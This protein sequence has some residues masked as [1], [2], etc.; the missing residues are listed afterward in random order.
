MNGEK[1][2]IGKKRESHFG[3]PRPQKRRLE[4]VMFN[5]YLLI[6]QELYATGTTGKI[7]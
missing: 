4:W 1:S 5:K 2:L 6:L 7:I 3:C